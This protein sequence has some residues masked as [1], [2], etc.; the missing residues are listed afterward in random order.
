MKNS[1]YIVVFWILSL[2]AADVATAQGISR[3]QGLGVR[4]NFWNITGRKTRINV[5][6]AQGQADVDLSGAGASLYYFSRAYRNVFLEMSLGAIGGVQAQHETYVQADVNVE[7]IIPFLVG[8]RYDF[9]ATRLS[10][11]IHPY[12]G[13]GGGPYSAFNIQST[14]TYDPDDT[15]QSEQETIESR[16]EYGW[17]VGGGVHFVLASWFALSADLKYHFIDIPE[18][19]DYSGLELGIGT[20]FMWGHKRQI[21]EIKDVK[22]VVQDVY[23]A[24]Y[25][26]YNTFPIA[27]VTV[28]NLVGHPIEVNIRGY[29]KGYTPRE[30]E[31]GVYRIGGGETRD[32]PVTVY[33]GD[34]LLDS[35]A[36]T[37]VILD[38]DVQVRAATTFREELSA[39]LTIHS[40]NAW[41]GDMDKLHLYLTPEASQIRE[42]ARQ[43]LLGETPD[44]GLEKF[45]HAKALF[46]TLSVMNIK[47]L[48]D[49]N[50]PFYQ[51]DRVQFATETVD[52]GSG[53][54]DDLVVLYASLLES[55]GIKT[56]FVEVQDPEKELAHLYVLFN[57]GLSAENGALISD[58]EKRYIVR[59]SSSGQKMIWIPVETTLL[60]A[61]F[62]KAW[63]AAAMAYLQEGQLRNG[64]TEGWVK[65]IDFQ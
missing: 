64:L 45:A 16:M 28:E 41:G 37:N 20:V 38:M 59:E 56:A 60:D 24:Y 42:L 27:L 30:K 63:T 1:L 44:F 65:I 39:Q 34:W 43:T 13:I 19:K 40:R 25:Q 6:N 26:F 22:L 4:M 51:D 7:S 8:L 31:S 12:I 54:C 35:D 14:G 57:T 11:A 49:P 2:V 48:P 47:Y 21:F 50:I 29:V 62:E 5:H 17:Y 52:A 15:F 23:P 3:S 55:V 36:S 18:I 9:M 61:G 58:N 53:D 10:G 46:D 33:F 32:I